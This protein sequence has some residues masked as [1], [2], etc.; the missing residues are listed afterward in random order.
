MRLDIDDLD[1]RIGQSLVLKGVSL[2]IDSGE[3]VTIMGRNGVGKSTLLRSIVGLER[4]DHGTIA[5]DGQ[6][7]TGT[8][9]SKL[10]EMGVGLV[11]QGRRLFGTLTVEEH[12]TKAIGLRKRSE[13][14]WSL[15]AVYE[16]FPVLGERLR[17]K[18]SSLSG[19]EQSM[20]SVAR[21]LR[22][23]PRL[24]LMDEPT[25]GLAPLYVERMV[26]VIPRIQRSG[27]TVVLVTPELA[28]ASA[29]AERIYVLSSGQVAFDGSIKQIEESEEL[30]RRYLGVGV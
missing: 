2:A 17:Q 5:L 30:Q 28:I 9:T 6:D 16:L 26:E 11:P 27:M 21:A 24:L 4:Q 18:A 25:E 15:E 8:R 14:A 12:L 19:G 23:G 10:A 22:V 20:L 29:L 1:V 7:V 3:L 13:R